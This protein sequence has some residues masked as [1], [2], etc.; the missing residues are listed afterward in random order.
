MSCPSER[1]YGLFLQAYLSSQTCVFFLFV[2]WTGP[3][4]LLR[5][6]FSA[7]DKT[8]VSPCEAN[9]ENGEENLTGTIKAEASEWDSSLKGEHPEVIL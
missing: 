2:L 3:F 8:T 5:H 1:K 6:I 9:G 7:A 4:F